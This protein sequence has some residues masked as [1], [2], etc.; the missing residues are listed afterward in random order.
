MGN[1]A[2]NISGIITDTKGEALVGVSIKELGTN[3][4]TIT[5]IEGNYSISVLENATLQF[6]YIGYQTVEIKSN[7]NT[8]LNVVMEE[9]ASELDELVV[10]GYGTV[11]KRDLTGSVTSVSAK[12]NS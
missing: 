4:G 5:D 9:T 8:V 6:S 3:T 2:K 7:N 12:K 10:V 11:K 1:R